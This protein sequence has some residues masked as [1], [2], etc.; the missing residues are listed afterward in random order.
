MV[1]VS[2]LA[3]FVISRTLKPM[4]VKNVADKVFSLVT[5]AGESGSTSWSAMAFSACL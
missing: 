3:V 2:P 5:A 4:S 1:A